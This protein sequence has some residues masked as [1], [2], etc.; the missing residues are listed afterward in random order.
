M[1]DERVHAPPAAVHR[2]RQQGRRRSV[3]CYNEGRRAWSRAIDVHAPAVIEARQGI[4][5]VSHPQLCRSELELHVRATRWGDDLDVLVG[6]YD[7]AGRVRLGRDQQELERVQVLEDE[8]ALNRL[9]ADEPAR[10]QAPWSLAVAPHHFVRACHRAGRPTAAS[11]CKRIIDVERLFRQH[12]SCLDVGC[13]CRVG[14]ATLNTV[15]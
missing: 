7:D 13:P 8:A 10:I 11:I 4:G 12:G 6:F 2:A 1:V 5:A 9:D 14:R 3:P 15:R